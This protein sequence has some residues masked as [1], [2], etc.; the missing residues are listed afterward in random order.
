MGA[1]CEHC[2]GKLDPGTRFC[3]SCGHAVSA[4]PAS[5]AVSGTP[6]TAAAAAPAAASGGGRAAKIIFAVLGVFTFLVLT[7]FAGC[8]Y[9]GY[10]IKQRANEFS[11][12]MGLNAK[13]YQGRRDPCRLVTKEEVAAA[14]HTPVVSVENS[15]NVCTYR[16]GGTRSVA[17]DV[18]W[19]GGTLAMKLAHGI[20]KNV[21]ADVETFTPVSGIGDET[22]VEPMG[23]GVMTRKGDVMVNIDLR[24][25][26]QNAEAGKQ[27]A[28]LIAG[29]L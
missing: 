19:E 5:P 4:A 20:M 12:N 25:A 18:T 13:P 14:F 1:F 10:R 11:Q 24:T 28:A 8:F 23:S 16:F 3:S 9:I 27:I 2:G 22:Y 29:R 26:G 17:V 7:A 15:G 21:V 6:G